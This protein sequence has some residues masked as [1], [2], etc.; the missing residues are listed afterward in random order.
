MMFYIAQRKWCRILLK[1]RELFILIIHYLPW[2]CNYIYVLIRFFIDKCSKCV[3]TNT[4][5]SVIINK[6]LIL[7]KTQHI[8]LLLSHTSQVGRWSYFKF[9]WFIALTV[10][11]LTKY[12]H[13]KYRTEKIASKGLAIFLS[14][15]GNSSAEMILSVSF[16]L[17]VYFD[18][19]TN[20]K[21]LKKKFKTLKISLL[22]N[23]FWKV[24]WN[25]N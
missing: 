10:L 19:V 1:K 4:A 6:Y 13:F 23:N 2:L 3:R 16:N 12:N 22:A 21:W 14:Q 5:P 24:Q 25:I 7:Q 20:L 11:F 15:R 17:S 8:T 9:Q 18:S